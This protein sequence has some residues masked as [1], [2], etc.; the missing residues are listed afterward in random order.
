MSLDATP[1]AFCGRRCALTFHHFIPKKV[2]RRAYFRKHYTR[3]ILQQGIDI[4]R[5]CHDGI[6]DHYDEMTLAKRFHT[7]SR[8]RRDPQLRKHFQWVK[9]QA[10]R[11]R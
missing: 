6:H 9:K 11:C 10:V 5:L 2:H 7:A 3:E 8:L 1:C 4:C